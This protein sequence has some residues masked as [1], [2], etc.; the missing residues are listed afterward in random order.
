MHCQQV[1]RI[2][3]R[4]MFHAACW[5]RYTDH[6]AN[7]DSM[8]CPNCRG[9][10]RMIAAWPYIDPALVTQFDPSGSGEQV[11]NTLRT[12]SSGSQLA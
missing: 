6:S 7:Q 9:P 5:E 11:P 3:C 4:H 2:M 8:S 1:C 12:V 10:G